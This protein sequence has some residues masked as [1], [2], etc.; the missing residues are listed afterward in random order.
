MAIDGKAN[1]MWSRVQENRKR[2]DACVGPHDFSIDLLPERTFGKRW[3]CTLCG[4]EIDGVDKSYYE[5]GVAHGRAAAKRESE[6]MKEAG[7]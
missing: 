1:E 2:M 7:R 3:R 5:R 6:T 4:A